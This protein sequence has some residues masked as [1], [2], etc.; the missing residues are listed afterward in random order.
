M[1]K[2][3]F[4]TPDD[5]SDID[6]N[7]MS[8]EFFLSAE[9]AKNYALHEQKGHAYQQYFIYEMHCVGKTFIP[10]PEILYAN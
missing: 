2:V 7:S 3:W 5:T 9:E 6:F 10:E 8:G 4:V 1:E